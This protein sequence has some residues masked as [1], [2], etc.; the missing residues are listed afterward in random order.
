MT[1]RSGC[2]DESHLYKNRVQIAC[3]ERTERFRPLHYSVKLHYSPIRLHHGRSGNALLFPVHEHLAAVD[4]ISEVYTTDAV[5]TIGPKE[6]ALEIDQLLPELLFAFNSSAD[7]VPLP[8]AILLLP[9]RFDA[10]VW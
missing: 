1:S 6:A 3:S 8:N 5:P 4:L 10:D 2:F 9:F 7:A